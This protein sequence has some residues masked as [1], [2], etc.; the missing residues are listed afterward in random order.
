[1]KKILIGAL[2]V[3]LMFMSNYDLAL[4][5]ADS[6]GVVHDNP[7]D[8]NGSNAY[9]IDEDGKRVELIDDFDLSG[10]V[11]NLMIHEQL[12][13]VKYDYTQAYNINND[14][15]GWIYFGDYVYTPY[16]DT[17]HHFDKYFRTDLYGNFDWTGIPFMSQTS[18]S[19]FD[20]NALIYGH[21][22]KNG[23]GFGNL[24]HIDT[25]KNFKE[26]PY[27]VL[28]NGEEDVFH[29]Y[30][31]YSVFN[32]I[33]GVE[34]INLKNFDNEEQRINYNKSLQARTEFDI[35]DGWEIDWS[36]KA[37]FLQHCHEKY[38][39]VTRRAVGFYNFADLDGHEINIDSFS[40]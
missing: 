4:N 17:P 36:R 28:Y 5:V 29:F 23:S 11:Q 19:S 22:M 32:V 3:L 24:K 31:V 30:K 15:S 2:S 33:D 18:L 14:V 40:P 38:G 12:K 37:L 6:T 8:G 16:V 13:K 1:M 35:E 26:A 7:E 9:I 21:N 27:L 39:G 34:F 25:A 10:S 20:E